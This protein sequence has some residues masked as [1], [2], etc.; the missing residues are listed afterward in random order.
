MRAR[1]IGAAAVVTML[2]AVAISVVSMGNTERANQTNSQQQALPTSIQSSSA[3]LTA[4]TVPFSTSTPASSFESVPS[5]SPKLRQLIAS[6]DE[7]VGVTTGYDPTYVGLAF[8]GGD[9]EK[10]TGVCSDVIIRSYRGIGI[11]LQQ[12][13]NIDMRANFAKYPTR[14]G[15]TKPDTNID[16]RRVPNLETFF[17]RKGASQE[18]SNRSSDYLPGDVVTWRIDDLPHTGLVTSTR[19]EGEDRFLI[20]HNVGQG[21]QREDVLFSWP[22]T[23]HFRWLPS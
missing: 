14:W 4:P 13:L 20:V 22:I 16:H 7:Q 21:T 10:S 3:P 19:V 12:E 9:V 2:A 18:I 23:G 5:S 15:L 17:A 11:D 8:P 1:W 6:A